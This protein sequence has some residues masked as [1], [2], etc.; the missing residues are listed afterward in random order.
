[1]GRRTKT[2]YFKLCAYKQTSAS[3]QKNASHYYALCFVLFMWCTGK[4]FEIG[5]PSNII[6]VP[7]TTKNIFRIK[8]DLFFHERG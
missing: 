8:C 1:M 7:C 6:K 5:N 3:G 2:Y 4:A